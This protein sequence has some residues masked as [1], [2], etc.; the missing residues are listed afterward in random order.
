[1]TNQYQIIA[2]TKAGH[3]MNPFDTKEKH[4]RML[5]SY[6][7]ICFCLAGLFAEVLC[8][9]KRTAAFS[10]ICWTSEDK[11]GAS[12]KI[13]K[14]R[15]DLLTLGNTLTEIDSVAEVD[16]V[17]APDENAIFA[18]SWAELK[19]TL[20]DLTPRIRT[21]PTSPDQNIMSIETT[22][23]DETL[24]GH[25]D[26]S[27]GQQ[28]GNCPCAVKSIALHNIPRLDLKGL[29]GKK[30]PADRLKH[31]S[32]AVLPDASPL[33]KNVTGLSS[34]QIHPRKPL[35][36]TKTQC[37]G[38]PV[39]NKIS[40]TRAPTR[41]SKIHK[42]RK[43]S[44]APKRPKFRLTTGQ[45]GVSPCCRGASDVGGYGTKTQWNRD[46]HVNR[47][48][49]YPQ[50]AKVTWKTSFAQAHKVYAGTHIQKSP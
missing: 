5:Y 44:G 12:A 24:L 29:E 46:T 15:P 16:G 9:R 28:I 41:L 37:N 34:K 42:S 38:A 33:P 4:F 20:S 27:A 3:W 31:N 39:K 2:K 50:S 30:T 13:K 25:N 10:G 6:W 7:L 1:M 19:E 18:D 8:T 17:S 21:P 35:T 45:N 32:F 49:L 43:K 40:I 14:M 48:T 22:S 23:S 11:T 36:A 26:G 47:K